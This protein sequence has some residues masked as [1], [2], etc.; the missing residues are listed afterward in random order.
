[1][2]GIGGPLVSVVLNDRRSLLSPACLSRTLIHRII[3]SYL[4]LLA[5]ICACSLAGFAQGVGDITDVHVAPRAKPEAATAVAAP[6]VSAPSVGLKTTSRPIK[7]DVNL[8][9]I[10]VTVTDPMNRLVTGLR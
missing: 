5:V 8:V 1:M 9:L 3:V 7:V 10:P 6:D 4:S 2:P